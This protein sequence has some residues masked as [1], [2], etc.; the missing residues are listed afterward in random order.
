MTEQQIITPN[1]STSIIFDPQQKAIIQAIQQ[2]KNIAINAVFGSGKT[3]TILETTKSCPN[4]TSIL[5]TYN[6]HLKNE[7]NEKITS[8]NL[9]NIDV[10]TYHSLCMKYFGYGKNDEELQ[11][12]HPTPPKNPLPKIDI[13]FI[14]EKQ[15]M[16]HILYTFI[17][18]F[19]HY[20]PCLPQ[21]VICGDHLQGVY[22]FKGAD[23]RFLTMGSEIYETPLEL[24]EM[25]TSYRLTHPMSWFI[26]QCIY[27]CTILHTVKEGPPVLFFNQSRYKVAYSIIERLKKCLE[28]GMTASDIFVLAPS[29]KGNQTLKT[30]ENLIYDTLHL[31]IFFTT[32]EDCELNDRVI[33]NKVVFSTFHQSK[34]RERKVVIV[35]GFDESYF[36]FYA[37]G[38]NRRDCPSTLIV[39]LSRAKEL[40]MIVK[41][42]EQKPLSFMKKNILEMRNHKY[43]ELIGKICDYETSKK[44]IPPVH[45]KISVTDLVRYIKPEIQMKLAEI[46]NLLFE[47]KCGI[48]QNIDIDPFVENSGSYNL[49]EDVS[50]LIG[51]I[52]PAV[53]EERQTG[54][55]N[56]K[57]KLLEQEEKKMSDFM[58]DKL[59]RV[60]YKSNM[61][62]DLLYMVKV[63]KSFQVGIYSP[64]QIDKDN[65]MSVEQ[66]E[67][68]LSNMVH[69]IKSRQ[70]YEYEFQEGSTLRTVKYYEHPKF[71]KIHI[72]GR[73]DSMDREIVW[74]FKCV[75]ELTLEHFLQVIC[76][77]W[78]W[79]FCLQEQYGE[80]TFRLLNIRT[81]EMYE[82]KCDEKLLVNQVME[83]LI[84]NRYERLCSISDEEFVKICLDTKNEIRLKI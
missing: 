17:Q 72:T 24:F 67:G 51:M 80:R 68:I 77:Q 2:E 79:N 61:I 63:Y 78:L 58:R 22:Q 11:L 14:D 45:R 54:V 9:T 53:F 19:I 40:L 76:Y 46:K 7:V 57:S 70:L 75:R 43:F 42:V 20:L 82:L 23:K 84:E 73:L 6:T 47:K 41:D 34:G 15:D 48:I 59:D 81:G 26:N 60:N 74:E 44:T 4:K 31:P 8:Q 5:V 62:E 65:W 29:L 38:E 25:N 69:H 36:D 12:Y 28:Q 35:F 18:K 37:K 10:Y 39:A 71:G 21:I 32:N 56:I 52:V 30:L 55:S 27:G 3:T 83:L 64:F 49:C 66:M 33:R 13:L 16:T 1:V 50:D